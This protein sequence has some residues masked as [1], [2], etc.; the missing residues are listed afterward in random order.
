MDNRLL[1]NIAA[2]STYCIEWFLDINNSTERRRD[3]KT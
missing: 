3:M 1:M 2:L